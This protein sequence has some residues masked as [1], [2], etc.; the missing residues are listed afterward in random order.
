LQ[1]GYQ[2]EHAYDGQE[3][4][5][6]DPA[7]PAGIVLLD[8]MPKMSGFDVLEKLHQ[9][10]RAIPK[11]IV[12]SNFAQ[13]ADVGAPTPL[14]LLVIFVKGAFFSSWGLPARLRSLAAAEATPTGLVARI[15]RSLCR[16]RFNAGCD[17]DVKCYVLAREN[18]DF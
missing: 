4:A 2:V 13:K 3:A 10:G 9:E 11:V 16:F 12:F 17:A 14:A 1:G 5:H 18:N 7:N 6:I 15:I 8:I